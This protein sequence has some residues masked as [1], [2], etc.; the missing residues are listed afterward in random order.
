MI[1]VYTINFIDIFKIVFFLLCKK[2]NFKTLKV[3]LQKDTLVIRYFTL[4][5]FSYI[6]RY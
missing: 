4:Y 3:A 1:F 2:E 6:F 5:L